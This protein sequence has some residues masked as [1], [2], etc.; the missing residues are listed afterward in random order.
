M[1]THP[2]NLPVQSLRQND[3]EFAFSGCFYLTRCRHGI[4]YRY[5]ARHSFQERRCQRLVH[6]YDIFFFV[7]IPCTQY[8]IH[9]ITVIGQK[10][11]SFRVLIQSPDGEHSLRI[12][13]EIN[14]II[15]FS[16]IGCTND[17]SRFVQCNQHKTSVLF[18]FFSCHHNLRIPCHLHP[19][20]GNLSVYAYF[21][22]CNQFIRLSA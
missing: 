12:L 4:Q 22:G 21:P 15:R 18:C 10:Q 20:H 19:G 11:K 3:T 14:D 16:L 9:D 5:A 1:L 13:Q 7:M 17:S 8:L 2:S 6:R